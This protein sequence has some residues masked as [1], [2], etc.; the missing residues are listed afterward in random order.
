M[1]LLDEIEL[2]INVPDTPKTFI[3]FL[4]QDDE[5]VYVGQTRQGLTRPFQHN[6]KE[7]NVV[8]IMPCDR[9]KLDITENYYI[10]KYKPKYNKTMAI[11]NEYTLERARNEIR[12]L[13]N[14]NDYTIRD[15]KQHLK[16]LN[17]RPFIRN[18]D[19]CIDVEDMNALINFIKENIDIKPI[20]NIFR[21][22][23]NDNES[24]KPDELLSEFD[25]RRIDFAKEQITSL[26]DDIDHYT[27][28]IKHDNQRI[29]EYQTIIKQ[30]KGYY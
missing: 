26:K 6:D 19:I 9:E 25:E 29:K 28:Y 27:Q 18:K 21:I 3:Y 8:K 23:I 2:T 16:V 13:F 11:A 20:K 7:F 24:F 15:L 14:C 30:I 12:K 17:I 10:N 1:K 4:L 22:F 5:V